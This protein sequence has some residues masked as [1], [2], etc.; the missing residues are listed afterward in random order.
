MTTDRAAAKIIYVD[1]DHTL[2]CIDLLR[3]CLLHL[4]LTRPYLL[5]A[6]AWWFFRGGPPRVKAELAARY[7]V[8][9]ADLPYNAA[10][11]DYLRAR[12]AAGTR[13][14]LASA[15]A[16]P[17]A[18]AVAAH[19]GLFDGVLATT[20]E[21][22]NVKG[23]RKLEFMQRD[24]NG[25]PFGYAGDSHAD[26]PILEAVAL[27]I[28][29]GATADLAGRNKG[30]AVVLPRA[31]P[32]EKSP[33]SRRWSEIESAA[34]SSLGLIMACTVIATLLIFLVLELWRPCYFLT[35][36]N[37]SIGLPL[38]TEMGRH[39]KQGQS[40]F[41]SD[42]IFGGHYNGL[43]DMSCQIWHPFLMG[44]SLL[45]DTP[46]RF[47]IIDICALLNLLIM[48]SGFTVLACRLRREF[49]L[50]ISDGYLLFFTLSY[51]F[52]NY[53]LTVGPSWLN[54]LAT[55]SC[56]PWL[57]LGILAT[58]PA[59]G[60]FLVFLF[61]VHDI[62]AGYAGLMVSAGLC[63]SVFA[64]GVARARRSFVPLFS[65]A[66]GNLIALLV[67]APLLL[68]NLDGFA[69][70]IRILGM[71]VSDLTIFNI[72][73]GEFLNSL[74]V[75]NWSE[76]LA[77]WHGITD[78]NHSS[79]PVSSILACAAAWC[80]WVA[81]FNRVRWHWLDK[82]C[83]GLALTLV[84][85]IVR[86]LWL[87][88]IM[89]HLPIFRSLRWPFR[90]GLLFLFF[91]HLLLILRWQAGS[92]RWQNAAAIF[93]LLAF[94]LPLP[95]IQPPSFNP[96]VADR[97]LLFSGRVETFWANVKPLLQPGDEIATVIDV[98]FWDQYRGQIPY[99]LPGTADSPAFLQVR[100]ISGYSPTAPVDQMPV[101][102]L[103][104]FWF[105]AYS[106][107]QVEKLLALRPNLKLVRIVSVHPYK[108]TMS[109]GTGPAVDL[110]PY[111]PK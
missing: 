10:V 76:L 88:V 56:L 61:T 49:A 74:F 98:P 38:V 71:S 89:Q 11:L 6:V 17:W 109:T 42:Y 103:P 93:G 83:L 105:G 3:D 34:H 52:S 60:T 31:M 85:F 65:W 13:L 5:L 106:E 101:A 20:P 29:V 23:R 75:G 24:A 26:I 82:L 40:P 92:R 68:L 27:P 36:D 100:S 95:F 33:R 86:P 21:S 15:T 47:W 90:E 57:T 30:I 107:D 96:L 50:P 35:D 53:T 81:L 97:E 55:Q 70:T 69:H 44:L 59:R 19:V 32:A 94:V 58:T 8:K 73:P 41:I 104:H 99:T 72:P 84:L 48:V 78:F 39:L 45:A 110:T 64:I 102:V 16:R 37:L 67:L 66:A 91:I 7:D 1:L 63:L 4:L 87:A 9:P 14:V 22:G 2:I 43:R 108:V 62:L 25:E 79:F 46:G 18:E 51:V 77:R 28:V 54:F 12:K 80:V 111:L